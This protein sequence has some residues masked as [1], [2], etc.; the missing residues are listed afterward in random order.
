MKMTY[1]L[2]IV[3]AG[4]T[5]GVKASSPFTVLE[6]SPFTPPAEL[7]K[8]Y[9]Q[10]VEHKVAQSKSTQDRK[11]IRARLGQAYKQIQKPTDRRILMYQMLVNGSQ[12]K[13][14]HFPGL[15]ASESGKLAANMLQM[16]QLIGSR[17]AAGSGPN[18]IDSNETVEKDYEYRTR[19]LDQENASEKKRDDVKKAYIVLTEPW[20]WKEF[21]DT[22]LVEYLE[23]NLEQA[24]E[25]DR[26][27]DQEDQ[28]RK[29]NELN[30][31]L[32]QERIKK[33]KEDA[34]SK[35][36][37]IQERKRKEEERLQQEKLKKEREEKAREAARRNRE[38]QDKIEIEKE[39][40]ERERQRAIVQQPTDAQP[41]N[42]VEW[43]APALVL[44]TSSKAPESVAKKATFELKNKL[45]NY[46]LNIELLQEGD[47]QK[48]V[49]SAYKNEAVVRASTGKNEEDHGYLRMAGLDPKTSYKLILTL[50]GASGKLTSYAYDLKANKDR[51]AIILTF[52]KDA[53][54]FVL[55]PQKGAFLSSKSQSGISLDGNIKS[56]DIKELGLFN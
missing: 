28:K 43:K 19:L 49:T 53:N 40:K 23:Q 13:A 3:M 6:I 15:T 56:S 9:A 42:S 34:D 24:Q 14:P 38:E 20:R 16:R 41:I 22:G 21:L 25:S 50:T 1:V 11:D 10:I 51:K 7:E 5:Q 17:L 30:E 36:R 47:K 37:E 55:R 32:E 18:I 4:L 2:L 46:G 54:T 29:Q 45:S 8:R 31:R 39:R 12:K 33:E 48:S 35:V 27:Q 52:E 44:G 26:Q